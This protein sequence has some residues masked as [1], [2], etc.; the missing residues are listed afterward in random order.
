M[1]RT[2]D[3]ARPGHGPLLGLALAGLTLALGCNNGA[4]APSGGQRASGPPGPVRAGPQPGAGP[5]LAVGDRAPDFTLVDQAGRKQSLDE[6][7]KEGP[8]AIVFFRSARG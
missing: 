3:R 6:L 5:S 8:V 2:L 7:R 4:P 1:N